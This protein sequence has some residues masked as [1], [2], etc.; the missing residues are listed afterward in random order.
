M[1]FRTRSPHLY[2]IIDHQLIKFAHQKLIKFAHQK[3][4]TL[5]AFFKAQH[6]TSSKPY[7]NRR[8]HSS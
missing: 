4:I 5:K 2:S 1:V 8:L 6:Y 7:N 3:L